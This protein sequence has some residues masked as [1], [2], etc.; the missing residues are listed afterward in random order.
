MT[1]FPMD[2]TNRAKLDA[3]VAFYEGKREASNDPEAKFHYA[4]MARVQFAIGMAFWEYG[5]GLVPTQ[6]LPALFDV[7]AKIVAQGAANM[8]GYAQPDYDK[9]GRSLAAAIEAHVVAGASGGGDNRIEMG[10]A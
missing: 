4:M 3:A 5:V 10:T 1:A 2:P 7:A 8:P 9:L 6:V